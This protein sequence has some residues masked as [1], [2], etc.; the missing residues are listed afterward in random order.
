MRRDLIAIAGRNLPVKNSSR[1]PPGRFGARTESIALA[2]P[3]A[4]E[5]PMGSGDADLGVC[6]VGS[7]G[8]P[9]NFIRL[10]GLSNNREPAGSQGQEGKEHER[11]QRWIR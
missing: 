8:S 10:G 6:A 7:R 9:R 1:N 2:R 4:F 11:T 3:T 5:P